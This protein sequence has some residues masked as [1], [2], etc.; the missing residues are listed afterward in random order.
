MFDLFRRWSG[1]TCSAC[2]KRIVTKSQVVPACGAFYHR[3]CLKCQ[4]CGRSATRQYTSDNLSGFPLL[5]CDTD[6][7]KRTQARPQE[8]VTTRE[9]CCG[10]CQPIFFGWPITVDGEDGK[11][12]KWHVACHKLHLTW[13]IYGVIPSFNSRT[14]EYEDGLLWEDR[15]N[16]IWSV[17][18]DFNAQVSKSRAVLVDR[19]VTRDMKA[20]LSDG[21][22]F[23]A[24]IDASLK[25]VSEMG[26]RDEV[27]QWPEEVTDAKGVLMNFSNQFQD[28]MR[29]AE[30]EEPERIR[31]LSSMVGTTTGSFRVLT[32]VI[33]SWLMRQD[34]HC[35]EIDLL[36]LKIQLVSRSRLLWLPDPTTIPLP[37]NA[38]QRLSTD[39]IYIQTNNKR[40]STLSFRTDEDDAEDPSRASA[41][42]LRRIVS[43]WSL[44]GGQ[45]G[46]MRR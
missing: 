19:L 3:D 13:D 17:S 28:F 11:P 15:I 7:A 31:T 22:H 12:A 30:S 34:I 5:L 9:Y 41:D 43:S 38:Q 20:I 2:S 29:Y 10:C 36:M 37:V 6:V 1:K 23:L 42:E 25:V 21:G 40:V 44:N 24:L 18:C 27:Q 14:D 33:L 45:R 39:S 46:G 4:D 8:P 32:K 35:K 26:S 16:T